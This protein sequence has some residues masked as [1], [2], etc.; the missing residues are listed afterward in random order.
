MPAAQVRPAD[1]APD[2]VSEFTNSFHAEKCADGRWSVVQTTRWEYR[3][4]DSWDCR[5]GWAWDE[6]ACAI[7]I[8]PT[9]AEAREI[10]AGLSGSALSR[11]A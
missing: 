2:S 6:E 9:E 3:E 4:E 8:V 5:G 10:V 11:A 7:E 1:L